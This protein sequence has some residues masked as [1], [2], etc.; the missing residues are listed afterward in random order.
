MTGGSLHV[1]VHVPFAAV[2]A[3]CIPLHLTP[4]AV[5]APGLHAWR[6]GGADGWKQVPLEECLSALVLDSATAL[7]DALV[8]RVA[9]HVECVVFTSGRG[10]QPTHDS[11]RCALVPL[12]AAVSTLLSMQLLVVSLRPFLCQLV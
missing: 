6:P 9:Y 12:R 7:L 1:L 4:G 5:D 11:S 8:Q 10:G 3:Q 2:C